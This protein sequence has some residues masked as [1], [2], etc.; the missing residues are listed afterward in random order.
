MYYS[1]EHIQYSLSDAA[2]LTIEQVDNRVKE[3]HF[4]LPF[5]ASD[6]GAF[7]DGNDCTAALNKLFL[8]A[9][10]QGRP[11][12]L[13]VG[14][15]VVSG[16][17]NIAGVSVEGVY[18][19]YHNQ[20]GTIIRGQGGHDMLE[21]G[22]ISRPSISF[23]LRNLRLEN[24]HTGLIMPYAVG[25][26]VE[27][28][29]VSGCVRGILLG[30]TGVSGPLWNRFQNV[31][32]YVA[33]DVGIELQG[34]WNNANVFDTCDF[35]ANNVC[36]KMNV[37]NGY[38]ASANYFV[39]TQLRGVGVGVE[40][41]YRTNN[42][43]FVNMYCE[44]QGPAFRFKGTSTK[45]ALINNVYGSLRQ[46]S[47]NNAKFIWHESGRC[48]L[49]IEGGWIA[50][51]DKDTQ[52]DLLFLDSDDKDSFF[53]HMLNPPSLSDA[54]S[55]NFKLLPDGIQFNNASKVS[56]GTDLHMGNTNITTTG[57]LTS[58]NVGSFTGFHVCTSAKELRVGSVVA[59]TGEFAKPPRI[60]EAQPVVAPTAEANQQSVFGVVSR[61][62]SDHEHHINSL[63]EGSILVNN[64]NGPIA[65]GSL[66]CSSDVEGI[67]M[68]QDSPA[69]YNYTVAKA[70][71]DET[72]D[73]VAYDAATPP[74][75]REKL[76]ACT[77]H[78]G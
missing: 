8:E 2:R 48:E 49:T 1:N 69:F 34:L 68:K 74:T 24:C 21:Q 59:S 62:I 30:Q 78:C 64:T 61:S 36:V 12:Q 75:Y 31:V 43:Q 45:D 26:K 14:T 76:I 19:G 60:S 5:H 11:A 51:A 28:V 33:S 6:F 22:D 35:T 40:M 65:N 20:Y 7:P 25:C 39:N 73:G 10:S 3:A 42:N 23:T 18:K 47:G 54:R 50:T 57:T 27:N 66:L 58:S 13:E 37:R 71:Q 46:N 44:V 63:G 16:S 55:E 53:L 9:R 56:Y 77:Y 72:F 15:Y 32:V 52:K 4:K 67:A 38:G 70:T 41:D 29:V 17:L